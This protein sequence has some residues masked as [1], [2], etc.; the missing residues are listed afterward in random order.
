M[1]EKKSE[2][3]G[4]NPAQF[5]KA[6]RG[7]TRKLLKELAPQVGLEPTTLRLTGSYLKRADS[8]NERPSLHRSAPLSCCAHS[9][10]RHFV[11]D[12]AA[13]LGVRK[14]SVARL[15]VNLEICRIRFW[16]PVAP[17]SWYFQGDQSHL[18]LESHSCTAAAGLTS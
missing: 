12:S 14:D 13:Y 3:S 11:A 6:Q 9:R 2:S 4:W 16:Y 8:S 1:K 18:L 5:G 7:G 10:E 15:L 17:G